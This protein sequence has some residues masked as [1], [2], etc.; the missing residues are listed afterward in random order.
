MAVVRL[1]LLRTLIL[2]LC[3]VPG[4]LFGQD[5]PEHEGQKGP[6][7]GIIDF[8]GIRDVSEDQVREALGVSEG[9]GLPRSKN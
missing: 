4:L 6:N 7:L 8:Y 5:A 2:T 9:G 1:M 3:L